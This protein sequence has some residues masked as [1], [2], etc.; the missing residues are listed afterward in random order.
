MQKSRIKKLSNMLKWT[1]LIS[2]ALAPLL[3]AGYWITDGYPFVSFPIKLL[4]DI[5]NLAPL[6]EMPATTKLYGFLLSL[7]PTGINVLA[8]LLLASLFA[9][10]EKLE[11]FTEKNVKRIKQIGGCVLTG[12]LMYPFYLALLSVTLTFFNP[13]GQRNLTI[14]FGMPQLYL[15]IIGLCT[16]VI[17]SI[18][19][20]GKKIREENA[21][22]I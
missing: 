8:L 20:E 22:T 10:F 5:P 11:F 7:I 2:A 3:V 1:F 13:V 6:S 4:P 17:S 16:L 15:L 14:G 12:A 21:C 18:M 19:E 9:S